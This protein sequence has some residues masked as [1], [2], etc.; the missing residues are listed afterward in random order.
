MTCAAALVSLL[1]SVPVGSETAERL[2]WAAAVWGLPRF[3]GAAR[4]ALAA[5]KVTP[6]LLVAVG[7]VVIAIAGLPLITAVVVAAVLV[8]D[9][10]RRPVTSPGAPVAVRTSDAQRA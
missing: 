10:V 1:P 4:A 6:V 7:L 2:A 3:L 9:L 5:R 8:S